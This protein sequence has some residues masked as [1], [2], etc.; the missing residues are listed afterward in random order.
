MLGQRILRPPVSFLPRPLLILQTLTE[1][2]S[3]PRLDGLWGPCWE[4]EN[5]HI[6]RC[7]SRDSVCIFSLSPTFLGWVSRQK[8]TLVSRRFAPGIMGTLESPE[9]PG[10]PGA[11]RLTAQGRGAQFQVLSVLKVT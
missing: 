3:E 4:P 7:F 6:A 2:I 11:A 8:I 5:F 9:H 10:T 1:A